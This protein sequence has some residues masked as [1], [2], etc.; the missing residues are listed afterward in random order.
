[1]TVLNRSIQRPIYMFLCYGAVFFQTPAAG[2]Q[3]PVPPIVGRW[4]LWVADG[5]ETYTSWVEIERSGFQALVERFVGRLGGARP[6]GK[7]EV[8]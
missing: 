6:I 8:V 7:I 4:N 5:G 3:T 1:M 2:A